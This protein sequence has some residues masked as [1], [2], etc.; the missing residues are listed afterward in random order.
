MVAGTFLFHLQL[1]DRMTISAGTIFPYGGSTA[2]SGFVLCDGSAISRT[3]YS[4]LFG[5]IGTTFG[6]GDGSTTFNVPDLRGRV[7]AGRDNMGGSAASRLTSTTMSPDGNTVGATGGEQTH[8][9]VTAE[10][11]S[12][13][14][15]ATVTDPDHTHGLAGDNTTASPSNI[16]G[17]EQTGCNSVG[18]MVGSG[19]IAF[20][21]TSASGQQ[22][23]ESKA[24][25][26][27]VTNANTGS[28]SAHNNVQPTLIANYIIATQNTSGG[29][30]AVASD[31]ISYT[32]F[33]GV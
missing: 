5:V 6:S 9:L 11:A 24:T 31:N 4:T 7:V 29:T 20:H 16:A 12:H 28:G 18:G 19:T 32:F 17:L 33:G 25:G 23:V 13:T 2:P 14:H 1:Y 10:L 3:T 27:T 21:T 15:T 26:I 22:L 8:T 30:P